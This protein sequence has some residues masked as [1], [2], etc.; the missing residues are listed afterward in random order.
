MSNT[1]H[2]NNGRGRV[3]TSTPKGAKGERTITAKGAGVPSRKPASIATAIVKANAVNASKRCKQFST[4]D[5]LIA[6]LDKLSK[7]PAM[8]LV[9]M[10]NGQEVKLVKNTTPEGAVLRREW[11]V[12]N[13]VPV[14]FAY[15]DG[16]MSR[17]AG[18]P[19]TANAWRPENAVRSR[20][21]SVMGALAVSFHYTRTDTN[22]HQL[23]GVQGL[24]WS[25]GEPDTFQGH[26]GVYLYRVGK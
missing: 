2:N 3:V 4:D 9:I 13:G 10:V 15:D 7:V 11:C 20:L 17:R 12:K 1:A 19:E 5:G 26:D 22:Y 16:M 25:K 14:V 6:H 24:D 23:V 8:P 21:I 18:Y